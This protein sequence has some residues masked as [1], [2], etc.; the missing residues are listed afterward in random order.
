MNPTDSPWLEKPLIKTGSCTPWAH[1]AS[2]FCV[3]FAPV[4]ELF[5][6]VSPAWTAAS[7]PFRPPEMR[8]TRQ[9]QVWS[10]EKWENHGKWRKWIT[11]LWSGASIFLVGQRLIRRI[12]SPIFVS[13]PLYPRWSNIRAE[14]TSPGPARRADLNL[15]RHAFVVHLQRQWRPGG[16]E[17]MP[18]QKPSQK[19]STTGGHWNKPYHFYVAYRKKCIFLPQKRLWNWFYLA[20]KLENDPT[21]VFPE[22]PCIVTVLRVGES[23]LRRPS[24][25]YFT[26]RKW[27]LSV[28]PNKMLPRWIRFTIFPKKV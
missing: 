7:P 20:A 25:K 12:P 11:S 24:S 16:G 5:C 14:T 10:R 22:A 9:S 6:T 21:L 1:G 26:C 4:P 13:D 3:I 27:G 2:Y 18:R 28:A 15:S 17:E 23:S 19:A 8:W